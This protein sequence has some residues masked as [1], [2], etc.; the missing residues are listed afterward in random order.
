MQIINSKCSSIL[1]KYILDAEE[2]DGI[3]VVD[4]ILDEAVSVDE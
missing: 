3:L 4:A 1:K 2:Y